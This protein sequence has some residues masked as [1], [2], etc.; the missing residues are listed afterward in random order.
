MG[1]YKLAEKFLPEYFSIYKF[2]AVLE[3]GEEN[4][5]E[6]RNIMKQFYKMGYIR[7]VSKNM[8]QKVNKN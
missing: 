7:R 5:R 8:Y 1:L 2:M 6:A 3:M 4:A